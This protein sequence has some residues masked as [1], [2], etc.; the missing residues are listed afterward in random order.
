MFD[1]VKLFTAVAASL[2]KSPASVEFL[3]RADPHTVRFDSN[4]PFPVG[5]MIVVVDGNVDLWSEKR[6]VTLPVT[7][8]VALTN[9]RQGGVEF[10]VYGTVYF[11]LS[12]EE[13]LRPRHAEGAK[14]DEAPLLLL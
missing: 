5:K 4:V 8:T 10:T 1:R 7:K 2:S 11:A 14:D 13:V 9:V 6:T 12:V 3:C